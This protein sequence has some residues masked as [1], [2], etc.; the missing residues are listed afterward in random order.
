M[1]FH[2]DW[3]Q[4]IVGLIASR[5]KEKCNRPVIAFASEGNSKIK[6]SVCQFKGYISEI[7]WS[8]LRPKNQVDLIIKFGGHSMAAGLTIEKHNYEEFKFSVLEDYE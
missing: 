8:Q 2:D 4:G 6:G 1:Y 5:L 3:H 7:F